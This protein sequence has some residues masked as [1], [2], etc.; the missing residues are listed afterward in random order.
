MS[1]APRS[2]GSRFGF[3]GRILGIPLRVDEIVTGREPPT[4]KTWETTKEPTL[5]VIGRHEMGLQLSDRN[6]RAQLN[7]YIRNTSPPAGSSACWAWH[8]VEPVDA[9]APARWSTTR[10]AL[11]GHGWRNRRL[12]A[13]RHLVRP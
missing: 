1:I 8:L 10:E 9:E 3:T 6:G 13:A 2:I 4:R 11:F 12:G 7:V 5:W